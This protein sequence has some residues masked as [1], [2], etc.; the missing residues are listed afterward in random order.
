MPLKPSPAA[1][2]AF[3]A[4]S[5]RSRESPLPLN[6]SSTMRP[7][8]LFLYLFGHRGAIERIAGSRRAWAVGALLVLTAGIAR[9]YDHLYLPLQLEAFLGPFVA[10]LFSTVFIFY[11]ANGVLKF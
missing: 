7:S 6:S 3:G 10:S 11:W 4:V 1:R 9:N 2:A 8:D 5:A